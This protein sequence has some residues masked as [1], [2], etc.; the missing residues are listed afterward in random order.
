MNEDIVE[1]VHLFTY[2]REGA[3]GAARSLP[4]TARAVVVSSNEVPWTELAGLGR[5]LDHLSIHLDPWARGKVDTGTELVATCWP[6]L[7]WDFGR[8]FFPSSQH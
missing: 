5:L 4:E 3:C 1:C 8:I 2:N 7:D 6:N